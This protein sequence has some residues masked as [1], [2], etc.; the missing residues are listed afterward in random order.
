VPGTWQ[1]ATDLLRMP[2]HRAI[3]GLL[4][5]VVTIVIPAWSANEII[6]PRFRVGSA[7]VFVGVW[8]GAVA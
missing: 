7:I 2:D 8:T 6:S 5:P 1:A 4:F 3:S